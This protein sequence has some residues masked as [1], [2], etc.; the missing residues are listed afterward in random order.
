MSNKGLWKQFSKE[1][2]NSNALVNVR[3][4]GRCVSFYLYEDDDETL[5]QVQKKLGFKSRANRSNIL[6][7]GIH[8]LAGLPE[9][10]MIALIESM[11]ETD[12]RRKK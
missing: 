10:A 4:K 6:R 1:S 8:A 5:A 12:G 7:A 2:K 9:S 3:E 11:T